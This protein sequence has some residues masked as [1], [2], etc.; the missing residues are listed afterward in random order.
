MDPL[1][2]KKNIFQGVYEKIILG[3]EKKYFFKGVKNMDPCLN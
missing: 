3:F 2:T 1:D